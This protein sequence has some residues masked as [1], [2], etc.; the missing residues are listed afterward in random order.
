[1]TQSYTTR[2]RNSPC[3][4]VYVTDTAMS[5]ATEHTCLLLTGGADTLL[6]RGFVVIVVLYFFYSALVYS[7][8]GLLMIRPKALSEKRVDL[9]ILLLQSLVRWVGCPEKNPTSPT[10]IC[11]TTLSPTK[12]NTDSV[13]TDTN[14]T[15]GSCRGLILL[16]DITCS[17]PPQLFYHH[18]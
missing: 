10:S 2:C 3:P 8:V 7:L 4:Q 5:T 16:A 12:V 18:S 17:L 13:H 1:M 9:T 11:D 6:C 14:S 15:Q